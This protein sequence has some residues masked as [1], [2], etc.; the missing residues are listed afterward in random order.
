MDPLGKQYDTIS[1]TETHVTNAFCN[2]IE[3]GKRLEIFTFG[4]VQ[5]NLLKVQRITSGVRGTKNSRGNRYVLL[6]VLDVIENGLVIA[7]HLTECVRAGNTC[8]LIT[9]RTGGIS[10]PLI[11]GLAR[12]RPDSGKLMYGVHNVFTDLIMVYYT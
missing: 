3:G 10:G 6:H 12:I 1:E 9:H 2:R 7:R 8:G 5:L 4:C 11:S